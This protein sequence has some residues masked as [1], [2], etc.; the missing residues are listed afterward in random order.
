MKYHITKKQVYNNY[1]RVYVC[2][3]GRWDNFRASVNLSPVA[4]NC[5][6]Y[7]WNWDLWE[8]GSRAI[9]A[10]YRSF[11]A[12]AELPEKAD[13]ILKNFEKRARVADRWSAT[14]EQYKKRALRNFRRAI[15]EA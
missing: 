10:G 14:W 7:G 15:A 13:R 12:A 9:V 8:F 11:P 2:N 1:S 4:Y 3:A 5:G 6:V